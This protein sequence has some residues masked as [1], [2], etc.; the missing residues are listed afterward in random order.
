MPALRETAAMTCANC[1]DGAGQIKA[2]GRRKGLL[3]RFGSDPIRGSNTRSSARLSVF[4]ELRSPSLARGGYLPGATPGPPDVGYAD[5]AV[6]RRRGPSHAP[7][8]FRV[9]LWV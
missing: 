1:E 2:F 5:K 3:M 9:N 6:G 7:D 8:T 4:G